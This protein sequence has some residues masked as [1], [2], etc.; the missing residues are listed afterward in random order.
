MRAYVL[1]GYPKDTFVQAEQRLVT[2]MQANFLPMAMLWRN[3]DGETSQPWRR[4]QREWANP[5]LLGIKSKEFFL[6]GRRSWL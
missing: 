5:I 4:F 1:V 3:Q 6:A 2:C